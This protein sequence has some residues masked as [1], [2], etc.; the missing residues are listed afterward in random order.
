M[1]RICNGGGFSASK[2]NP[3]LA[4]HDGPRS[5]DNC[6]RQLEFLQRQSCQAKN[7]LFR[8]GGNNAGISKVGK[9]LLKGLTSRLCDK[10]ARNA[11]QPAPFYPCHLPSLLPRFPSPLATHFPTLA[12]PL[13]SPRSRLQPRFPKFPA[14]DAGQIFP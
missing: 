8:T 10:F 3:S 1:K 5:E 9:R 11:I 7:G 6:P 13:L 12:E 14:A 2:R 4:C